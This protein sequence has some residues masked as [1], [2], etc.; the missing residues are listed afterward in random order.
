MSDKS[1]GKLIAGIVLLVS[2]AAVMVVIFMPLFEGGNALNYL[3]NLYNSISKGSAYYIVKMQHLV[4]V[5]PAEDVSL[6]L[7][8]DDEASAERVLSVLQA[9]GISA[10]TNGAN[11][12]VVG[13]FNTILDACLSDADSAYH[14]RGD[15]LSAKY[16]M[17]PRAS[18]HS[19]W[20]ALKAMEKDLNRQ[21]KF[22]AA[23]LVHAIQT[24]AVETSYNYY[25]IQP[26]KIADRWG[27]VLFSLVFYV[28]YTIW[29]GYAIMFLFEGLGFKLAH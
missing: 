2:F 26:S 6:T 9:N 21:K 23:H 29:Y 12:A 13:D 1:T 22:A 24:K 17:D 7:V 4:E 11:V 8:M 20:A 25:G 19:W 3:D 27:T 5:H 15:E 16:G 28:V 18:L 14:N 10:N